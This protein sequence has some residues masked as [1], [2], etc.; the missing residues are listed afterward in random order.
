MNFIGD[1]MSRNLMFL[2]SD[3]PLA[4]KTSIQGEIAKVLPV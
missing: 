4:T 3:L 2:L 1:R